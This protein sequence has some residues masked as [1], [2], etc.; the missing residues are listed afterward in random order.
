MSQAG[1]SWLM[2]L[3]TV[4][5]PASG[6]VDLAKSAGPGSDAHWA[7][8]RVADVLPAAEIERVVLL[9]ALT[10]TTAAHDLAGIRR[11][12]RQAAEQKFLDQAPRQG[13]LRLGREDSIWEAVL[14][15]RDGAVFG[16]VADGEHACLRAAD[17]QGGCF[18]LP[19]A[20]QE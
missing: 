12:L 19:R 5:A 18:A 6:D 10:S 1:L 11:I 3:G 13:L 20:A 8:R 16:F 4:L 9:K 17:G 15:V 2:A 7:G 14:V